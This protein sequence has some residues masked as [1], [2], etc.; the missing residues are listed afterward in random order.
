MRSLSFATIFAAASGFMV[1]WAAGRAL[2]VAD[3]AD[4]QAYW[5]LFFAA[6][7]FIDGLM[8][9][10]TRGVAGARESNQR[11]T[12][13]PWRVAAVFGLL[14]TVLVA[15]S[16]FLW[17]P[18]LVPAHSSY[19]AT[20]LLVGGLFSYIF[21]AVLSGILSGT[22]AWSRYAALVAL[23]SGLRLVA[24]FLAWFCGWGLEV[25]LVI[26]VIGTISWL[27]VAVLD[28]QARTRLRTPVDTSARMFYRKALSA[29]VATGASA[30][31]ITGFPVLVKA[32]NPIL[33]DA[34]MTVAGLI[35]AVT[36][37]RAPILVPLQRFQSALVVRCIAA[38][39][40]G[41]HPVR[42]LV[43]P[44][45]LTLAAGLLGGV[46]AA[47]L[48]PWIIATFF[49]PE[50][51]VPGMILGVLTLAS[52]ATGGLIMTGAAALAADKHG[53]YIAGWV[54]STAVAFAVLLLPLSL[55][56]AVCLALI[57]GPVAGA[58][59]HLVGLRRPPAN[60]KVAAST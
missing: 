34:S 35:L 55:D 16:F 3:F 6:T 28:P 1:L 43:F 25:F 19:L 32:S 8:L 37:T 13:R 5:G 56:R 27:V 24:A 39:N 42:A 14:M 53:R 51:V 40:Q 22:T 54:I 21:Q 31:L 30:V 52:A 9:E 29:M 60:S 36:L 12:A 18:L 11:G 33:P 47:I 57:M 20:V 44:A 2:S 26:T 59:I 17:M 10:T 15:A 46:A 4:F 38:L 23:D 50:L 7:G 48:G 49:G 58:L 45:A 41:L